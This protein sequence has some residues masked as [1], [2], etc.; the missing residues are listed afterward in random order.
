MAACFLEAGLDGS[1]SADRIETSVAERCGVPI[2]WV[3]LQERHVAQAFQESL[4]RDVAAEDRA[5]TLGP[6]LKA[7]TDF[8][9]T[10]D[11]LLDA[12]EA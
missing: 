3:A 5:A 8:D 11:A 2:E 12:F 10:D 7:E 4:F 1:T 9:E 6:L